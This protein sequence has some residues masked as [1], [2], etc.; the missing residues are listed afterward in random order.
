METSS[1]HK[2]KYIFITG[3]FRSGTTLLS[4]ALST[5]PEINIYYQ[6][7]NRLFREAVTSFLKQN[8]YKSSI[9]MGSPFIL[10][11]LYDEF[12]KSVLHTPF[13]MNEQEELKKGINEDII[14][15]RQEKSPLPVITFQNASGTNFI[16]LLYSAFNNI[17]AN[18]KATMVGIKEIWCEDFLPA[19][20]SNNE[21][22]IMCIHLIRDPRAVIVSRNY[23]E[24]L[25][26]SCNNKKYPL[27]FICRAWR[28]SVAINSKL[29]GSPWYSS[30]KYE[31]LVNNPEET[32]RRLCAFLKIEFDSKMVDYE[33]Y[34]TDD[35]RVWK[36]NVDSRQ[37]DRIDRANATSWMNTISGQDLFLSEYLC[38][39]EMKLCGYSLLLEEHPHDRF[40][41]MEEE[42]S[43]MDSWLCEH[44]HCL[45]EDQKMIELNRKRINENK[46]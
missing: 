32:I 35:N 10:E 43:A 12:N 1:D 30:V 31:Q 15:D 8:G 17:R 45:T 33:C 27:L 39:E 19:L 46:R 4:R 9:P 37:F 23:S 18:N 20:V 13:S 38:E 34:K 6:P 41:A 44:G 3:I 24:Y 14:I 2:N 25:Q 42:E 11:N 40:M 22:D 5:H 16:E 21:I 29:K 36:G 28:R 7:Y 26:R